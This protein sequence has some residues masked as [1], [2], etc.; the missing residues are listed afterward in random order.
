MDNQFAEFYH[1]EIDGEAGPFY[2]IENPTTTVFQFKGSKEAVAAANAMATQAFLS[3]DCGREY[4]LTKLY[5]IGDHYVIELRTN[6]F[7][8]QLYDAIKAI[9]GVSDLHYA[10]YDSAYGRMITDCESMGKAIKRANK[11]DVDIEVD[12][13]P[14]MFPEE[15]ELSLPPLDD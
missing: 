8:P 5:A 6:N 2:W 1:H 14:D 13:E 10:V 7:I 11:L 3:S 15:T 4:D 12:D 9:E